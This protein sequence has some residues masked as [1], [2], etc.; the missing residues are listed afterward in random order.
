MSTITSAPTTAVASLADTYPAFDLGN[1]TTTR[2]LIQAF[3]IFTL[4][5]SGIRGINE[6]PQCSQTPQLADSVTSAHTQTP[7]TFELDLEKLVDDISAID[8]SRPARKSAKR[9]TPQAHPYKRPALTK[10][11]KILSSHGMVKKGTV[12]SLLDLWIHRLMPFSVQ[13][14]VQE[15]FSPGQIKSVASKPCIKM[16]NATL[17]LLSNAPLSPNSFD[18]PFNWS[19]AWLSRGCAT[20]TPPPTIEAQVYVSP[21]TNEYSEDF[22]MEIVVPVPAIVKEREPCKDTG[23]IKKSRLPKVRFSR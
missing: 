1:I 13:P 5:G 15:M 10:T 12:S 11:E 9:P 4:D 21:A 19:T 17:S 22:P 20:S 8:I 18:S 6:A 3:S 23:K 14:V 16:N 2:D 7:K